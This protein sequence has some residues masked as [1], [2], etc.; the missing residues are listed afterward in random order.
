[1]ASGMYL[2]AVEKMI[3]PYTS[4]GIHTRASY[5]KKQQIQVGV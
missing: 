2:I 5:H 3:S 1:M 4:V